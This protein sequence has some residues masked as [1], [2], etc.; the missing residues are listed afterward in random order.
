MGDWAFGPT[1]YYT[2]NFPNLGADGEYLSG[3]VKY[4]APSTMAALERSDR[5]V[6]VG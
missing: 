4:T 2:P 5:L 1:F 3:I 6:R